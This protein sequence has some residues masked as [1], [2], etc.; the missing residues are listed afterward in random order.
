MLDW[1]A[2]HSEALG[3]ALSGATLIVWLVYAQLLYTS[4]R[5][6]WR[7]R[8]LINRGRGKDLDA[9]CMIS[10]MSAEAL[11]I[12]YIVADLETDATTIRLD[13]TDRDWQR[14]DGEDDHPASVSLSL[15]DWTHQGPLESAGYIHIGSFRDLITRI[16]RRQAK[17]SSIATLHEQ[18]G[19]T[20]LTIRVIGTYG[21]ENTPVGGERR[22]RL[23]PAEPTF[24]LIPDTWD[25]VRLSS[26]R[27]RRSLERLIGEL[28]ARKAE[29]PSDRH[30]KSGP[31]AGD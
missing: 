26:W 28:N 21:S 7:P 20:A 23:E 15:G 10:N 2:S 25:T 17:G 11:F 19:L 5:R 14:S 22:F 9:L 1:I 16:G 30:G 18:L 27:E 31:R 29:T 12:Q 24:A 13:V 8:L 6:Q 4:F 3:L